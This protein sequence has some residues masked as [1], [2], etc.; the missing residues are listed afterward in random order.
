MINN[1][2]TSPQHWLFEQIQG[3]IRWR[4][5]ESAFNLKLFD[6]LQ[7]LQPCTAQSI[8]EE[9]NFISEQTCIFLD[10]LSSMGVLYKEHELYRLSPEF[11]PF[12]LS[13]SPQSMRPVLLHLATIKHCE[14]QAIEQLLRS[15]SSEHASSKF[16]GTAI[17]DKAY[18][19]LNSFHQSCSNEVALSILR[20]LPTWLNI[21][22]FLDLGAG[23]ECL[24]ASVWKE[25]NRRDVRLFDLPASAQRIKSAVT[26]QDLPLTVFGGD[27][28]SDEIPGDND[29]IWAAMSLYY[30]KDL[31]VLLSKLYDALHKNGVMVALHEGLNPSR[32]IPEYHVISRVLPALNGNDLSFQKG[33]ISTAMR[34]AGFSHI[35][36]YSIETSYGPFDVDIAFK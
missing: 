31:T 32:T 33:E 25:D 34:K 11:T 3:P 24:S 17:W 1:I 29:V 4:L 23:S 16:S 6:R 13:D 9:F 5:L 27:Y 28:N 20:Q 35:S 15:G 12:L 8:A 18:N 26:T 10:A 7:L 19:N 22:R 21:K 30:A 14:P 36:S 2:S